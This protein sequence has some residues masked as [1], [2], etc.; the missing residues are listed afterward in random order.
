V[1]RA[2]LLPGDKTAM[3]E[4]PATVAIP[5]TDGMG[6]FIADKHAVENIGKTRTEVIVIELKG[7]K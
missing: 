1:P 4:H 7:K 6:R 3:H 5:R 2:V